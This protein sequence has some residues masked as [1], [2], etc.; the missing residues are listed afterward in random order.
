MNLAPREQDKLTIYVVADL[1]RRRRDR[2]VELNFSEA[3]ALISEAILEGARDG[4]TVAECM[5]LGKQ[6]VSAAD[7]MDGVREMADLIQVEATFTDGTKLVS[8]HDPVGG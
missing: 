6:V 1:A 3:V 5:E 7:V 8:C 4:K 2:G